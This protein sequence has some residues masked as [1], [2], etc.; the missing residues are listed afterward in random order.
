MPPKVA[1]PQKRETR[2]GSSTSPITLNDIKT[3][4]EDLRTDV[5]ST[6]KDEVNKLK[7]TISSLQLQVKSLE[8]K[9]RFLQ[10]KFESFDAELQT[11]KEGP[12]DLMDSIT[13]EVEDRTRRKCNIVIYGLPECSSDDPEE[14][15]K[16]K[17]ANIMTAVSCDI[18]GIV[19]VNRIGKPNETRPRLLKVQCKNLEFRNLLLRRAK[20]LRKSARYKG[21]FI[22]PDR[23]PI[24]Q[25]QYKALLKEL[26]ERK[27]SNENVV[28]FR[29]RIVH[30]R[31]VKNF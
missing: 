13:A 26:K 28:I 27:D 29:N 6:L 9:N 22:N 5:I 20:E 15:D 17:C 23:T 19:S 1:T 12:V 4:I 14:T 16:T 7:D 31:E 21:I 3:L 10:W 30:R 8:D 25:R 2:S 11:L 24:E 18:D